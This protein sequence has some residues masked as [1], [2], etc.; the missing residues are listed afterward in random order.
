MPTPQSELVEYA[1]GLLIRL[2][3][4]S[5]PPAE[6]DTLKAIFEEIEDAAFQSALD[7]FRAASSRFIELSS[8]LERA[9]AGLGTGAG[10]AILFARD[11]LGSL[12]RLV[13]DAEGMRTTWQSSQEFE[14]VFNDETEEKPT[15]EVM[16]L[17]ARRGGSAP[18]V[19]PTPINSRQYPRLAD[20]YVRFFRGADFSS[21]ANAQLA[22]KYAQRAIDNRDHYLKVGEPLGIPWWFIA[23]IHLLES[24]F[25]FTTHLHNGDSLGA[26]THRVPQGRPRSGNP[27]FTWEESAT[28]ALEME[29]LHKVSDWSLPRALFRWEAYNGFGYRPRAV[30]SPYLWSFTT[31]YSKGKFVGDGV[32]STSAV[33]KQCGAAAFLRALADLDSVDLRIEGFAEDAAS[34]DVDSDKADADAAVNGGLPNID[35]TVSTN[36]D[37]QTFF[38]ERVP[39]VADFQWHEFLVKGS[40]HRINGLNTDPP[41]ELW[42]NIQLTARVLQKLR[43]EVGKPVVL[44]SVY[45][46]PRYNV[47]VGGAR[48]SQHMEF[49][50]VDFKIVG[51]GAPADWA[52]ILKRYRDNGVFDGGVGVYNTFVHLDTR[53][54]PA[55]W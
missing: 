19:S 2:S 43:A 9:I 16:Q 22:R 31:I 46:S 45:R 34:E 47:A 35:G 30:P 7:N 12:Q 26:R 32:F 8:R 6:F 49:T 28:D 36:V 4:P 54:Y 42:P 33:S 11:G 27:P 55:S 23:G 51:A 41:R 1:K 14:E 53:G 20:E 13:H 48:H 24:G 44:T 50:A 29:D 38:A 3:S 21:S 52:R 25:N 17:P 5:L 10:P 40:S 15:T 39:D 37:F 18:L